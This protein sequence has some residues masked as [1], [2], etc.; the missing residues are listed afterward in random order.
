MAVIDDTQQP[1]FGEWGKQLPTEATGMAGW[2]RQARLSLV[3]VGLA[4][5]VG[6][7]LVAHLV[8]GSA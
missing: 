2:T 1:S 6:A 7:A 3:I 8:A 4:C 5:A